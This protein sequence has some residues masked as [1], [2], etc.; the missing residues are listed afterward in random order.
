LPLEIRRGRVENNNFRDYREYTANW[1]S[2][3][4]EKG[5]SKRKQIHR[6][7]KSLPPIGIA[8]SKPERR[9]N[10]P[11]K[12]RARRT[13]KK[14]SNEEGTYRGRVDE[15]SILQPQKK[16]NLDPKRRRKI[17][18]RGSNGE[19]KGKESVKLTR[20]SLQGGA[21]SFMK[22]GGDKENSGGTPTR[23]GIGRGKR[24]FFRGTLGGSA[25]LR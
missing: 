10:S 18:R 12:K 16:K 11:F 25:S 20:R 3:E 5:E 15:K 23:Q 17:E 21:R 7:K 19:K 14:F 22:G 1:G 8:S 24:G 4:I 6:S 9:K 13:T 2:G